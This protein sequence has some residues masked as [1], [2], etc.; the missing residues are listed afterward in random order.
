[1]RSKRLVLAIFVSCLLLLYFFGR[2]RNVVV[3]SYVLKDAVAVPVSV[4]MVLTI[5]GK[6]VELYNSIP[7]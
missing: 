4:V 6:S 1:M 5:A 2:D 7:S 3:L